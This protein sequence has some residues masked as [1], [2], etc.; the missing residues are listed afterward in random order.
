MANPQ[1]KNKT[2]SEEDG[3]ALTLISQDLTKFEN[4]QIQITR[5]VFFNMRQRIDKARKNYWGVF[6]IPQDDNGNDKSWVPL[7]FNLTELFVRNSDL[8]TKDI[9]VKAKGANDFGAA[10]VASFVLR[11]FLD[12]LKFGEFLNDFVR[13]FFIDGTVVT[14][15]MKGVDGKMVRMYNVDLLNWYIDPYAESIQEA[16]SVIERHVM[17][18]D[19]FMAMPWRNKEGVMGREDVKIYTDLSTTGTKSKVPQVAVY[20]RWGKMPKFCITG[21]ES[22]RDVWIEGTIIASNIREEEENIHSIRENKSGLKPYQEGR[23]IKAISR[24]AG[25]GVPEMLFDLQEQIN[26]TINIRLNNARIKQNGLFKAKIGSGI[27]QQ[28]LTRLSSGGVIP[29][30]QMDDFQELAIQDLKQSTFTMESN[31]YLWAQRVTG[32]FQ[33]PGA[34]EPLPASTTATIGLLQQQNARTAFDMAQEN[35]GLALESIIKDHLLPIIFEDLTAEDVVRITGEKDDLAALDEAYVDQFTRKEQLQGILKNREVP[36]PTNM[37]QAREEALNKFKAQGESRWV[38]I[39]KELFKFDFDIEVDITGEKF[40]KITV[41][42]QLRQVLVELSQIPDLN[43]DMN[44]IAKEMLDIMGIGGQRFFKEKLS[45][46]PSEP[47]AGPQAAPAAAPARRSAQ[48]TPIDRT[49]AQLPG[50][51]S[52]V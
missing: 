16:N 5:D 31:T 7:T 22:D 30:K 11:H 17:D 26:E 32:G 18:I 47:A 40:D 52:Q 29:V 14:K 37:L 9:S 46:P 49:L 34:G 24:W 20:E 28:M 42:S 6:E 12:K 38:K 41:L 10:H 23:F 15:I 36:S 44:A 21:I 27:T 8:D 19:E 45:S 25:I 13:R 39:K 50:L 1:T 43:L 33:A 4:V 3:V 35:L 48:E 2:L 51:Q